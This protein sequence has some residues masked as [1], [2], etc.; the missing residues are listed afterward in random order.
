MYNYVLNALG[1]ALKSLRE[2]RV[3]RFAFSS[4]SLYALAREQE[5]VINL[6]WH[7]RYYGSCIYKSSPNHAINAT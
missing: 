1:A 5:T 2:N 4:P 3:Q 7:L 6:Q